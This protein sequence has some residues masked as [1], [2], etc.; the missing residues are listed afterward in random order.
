MPSWN[1]VPIWKPIFGLSPTGLYRIYISC[2]T[3]KARE[4]ND[5]QTAKT[6]SK[7][8]NRM[9]KISVQF[10]IAIHLLNI[11]V[12]SR[13]RNSE[14]QDVAVTMGVVIAIF[15]VMTIT[16]AVAALC[17]RGSGS[18]FINNSCYRGQSDIYNAFSFD[19]TLEMGLRCS[20]T[21]QKPLIQTYT[22]LNSS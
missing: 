10:G 21:S 7:T 17:R 4:Q 19:L 5:I 6:H 2:Q 22:N 15:V 16:C 9:W 12:I 1:P 3:R 20:N 13:R 8:A 14:W 18:D 11:V